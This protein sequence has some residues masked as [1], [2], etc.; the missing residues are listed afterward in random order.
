MTDDEKLL[1][2]GE[3]KE[4]TLPGERFEPRIVTVPSQRF[5]YTV[6]TNRPFPDPVTPAPWTAYT[7]E[8]HGEPWQ[9]RTKEEERLM[10]L[11]VY[12][13]VPN[14]GYEPRFHSQHRWVGDFPQDHIQRC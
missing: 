14:G 2:V 10:A 11:E 7:G 12:I 8:A 6:N 13:P 3:Y 1:I 4:Y 5:T 9:P